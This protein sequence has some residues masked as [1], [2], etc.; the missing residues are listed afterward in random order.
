[1][2]IKAMK[3]DARLNPGDGIQHSG[4]EKR[5]RVLSVVFLVRS[6]AYCVFAR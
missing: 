4:L 1:M 2:K 3:D 5:Q 6:P